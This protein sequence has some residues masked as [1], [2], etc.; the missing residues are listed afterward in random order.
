MSLRDYFAARALLVI[1]PIAATGENEKNMPKE[2]Q[3]KMRAKWISEQCYF[4]ADAMLAE[5]EKEKK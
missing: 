2:A 5:R 3:G 1:G 4:M